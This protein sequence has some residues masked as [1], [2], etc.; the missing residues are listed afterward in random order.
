[1]AVAADRKSGAAHR[2]DRKNLKPWLTEP[3]KLVQ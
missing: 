3:T 2:M 1:M